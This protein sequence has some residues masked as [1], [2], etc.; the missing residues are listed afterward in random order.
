MQMT[1]ELHAV[2]SLTL[3][4]MVVSDYKSVLQSTAKSQTW[5]FFQKWW[6]APWW[7]HIASKGLHTTT[8]WRK[9]ATFWP[10]TI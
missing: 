7:I 6:T 5:S 10:V 2:T 1:A 3:C 9:I 8:M 4:P